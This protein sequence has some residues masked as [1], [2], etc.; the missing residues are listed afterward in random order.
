[1]KVIQAGGGELKLQC[2][3]DE[4][5]ILRQCADRHGKTVAQFVVWLLTVGMEIFRL[6]LSKNGG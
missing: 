5:D 3:N 1:M 2:S 4:F 6:T